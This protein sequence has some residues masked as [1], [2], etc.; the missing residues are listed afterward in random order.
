MATLID[1]K[2]YLRHQLCMCWAA[3]VY[4]VLCTVHTIVYARLTQKCPHCSFGTKICTMGH[5]L[6]EGV[7]VQFS[8][9]AEMNHAPGSYVYT[10]GL[11]Y[12]EISTWR[13]KQLAG[14]SRSCVSTTLLRRLLTE[15]LVKV[16]PLIF[17]Y[18]TSFLWALLLFIVYESSIITVISP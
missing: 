1:R 15:Q 9:A 4:C 5:S 8:V 6:H 11:L 10:M 18:K 2:L 17:S 7:R 3:T 16:T 13:T 14:S 12:G